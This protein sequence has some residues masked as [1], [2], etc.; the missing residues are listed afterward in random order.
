MHLGHLPRPGLVITP[1]A[2]TGTSLGCRTHFQAVVL[3]GSLVLGSSMREAELQPRYHTSARAGA[4]PGCKDKSSCIDKADAH[5]PAV[6]RALLRLRGLK[7][8]SR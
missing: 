4:V 7:A 3:K 5:I 2:E 6:A 8:C 1:S